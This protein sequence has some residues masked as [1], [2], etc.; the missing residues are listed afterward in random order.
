M[1]FFKI[2]ESN[3]AATVDFNIQVHKVNEVG[4]TVKSQHFLSKGTYIELNGDLIQ[5]ITGREKPLRGQISD[6][7][8]DEE[9]H[10]YHGLLEFDAQDLELLANIRHYL[11]KNGHHTEESP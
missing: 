8:I 1:P 5:S 6:G 4:L 2:T 11:L 9:T 3:S 10:L 7:H